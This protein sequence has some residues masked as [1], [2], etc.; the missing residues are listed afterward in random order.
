MTKKRIMAI[1]WGEKR[2]GIA[3]SDSTNT[4]ASPLTVLHK[5]TW[6]DL[7]KLI[8]VHNVGTVVVGIPLRTDGKP[9]EKEQ[10]VKNWI[11]EM[12]REL[13]EMKVVELDERFTTVQAK[14]MLQDRGIREKESRERADKIA[15]ALILEQYLS[16]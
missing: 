3:V 13:P 14:R 12:K 9:G 2:I 6:K 11:F 10:K 16:S 7:G 5:P 8:Q 1:D 15:A 4:L